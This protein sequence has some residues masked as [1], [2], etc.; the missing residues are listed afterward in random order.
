MGRGKEGGENE[1]LR[2]RALKQHERRDEK[3]GAELV[4]TLTQYS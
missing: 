3:R 2:E 1:K 4:L